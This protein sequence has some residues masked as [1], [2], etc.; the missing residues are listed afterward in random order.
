MVTIRVPLVESLCQAV[1][2]RIPVLEYLLPDVHGA[3]GHVL[4]CQIVNAAASQGRGT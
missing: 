1:M 4:S 2:G 3:C